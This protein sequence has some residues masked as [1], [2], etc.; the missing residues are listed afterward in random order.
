MCSFV[1]YPTDTLQAEVEM[2]YSVEYNSAV[3]W[4]GVLQHLLEEIQVCLY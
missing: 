2:I 3:R 4:L 1:N